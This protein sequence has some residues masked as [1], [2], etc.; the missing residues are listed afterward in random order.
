MATNQTANNQG[1]RMTGNAYKPTDYTV[2]EIMP[3]ANPGQY[4]ITIDAI[5]TKPNKDSYMMLIIEH[6]IDACEAPENEKFIGSTVT[7]FL[8]LFPDSDRKSRMGKLDL[9]ALCKVTDVD[10]GLLP[11]RI[12]RDEDV[13]DFIA[14]LTGKH[15]TVWVTQR[16]AFLNIFYEAPPDALAAP[17]EEEERTSV[18]GKKVAPAAK[19]PAA[20]SKG[21]R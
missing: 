12:E 2:G 18:R 14:A 1:A 11:T 5:K 16:D 8:T 9:Q 19:R 15:L 7:K 10:L 21:R 13:A 3:D 17:V 6:K 20:S 4:D